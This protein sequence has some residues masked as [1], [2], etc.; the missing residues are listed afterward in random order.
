MRWPFVLISLVATL[1]LLVGGGYAFRA[2][3]VDEPLKA[4]YRGSSAVKSFTVVNQG[5]VRAIS[6]QLD[7]VPDL[8][9]VYRDLDRETRRLLG[10]APYV[11][12]LKDSRTPDQEAALNRIHL[13]IQEALMTGGFADMADRINAEAA[14]RNMVARVTVDGDFVYLQL[15]QGASVLYEVTPRHPQ[16]K[17]PEGGK[18]F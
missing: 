6:L 5:A 1:T 4:L 2:R 3:T 8:S 15:Q 16:R 9:T 7:Q 10:D 17:L 18:L 11:I 14:S 13:Y 12:T